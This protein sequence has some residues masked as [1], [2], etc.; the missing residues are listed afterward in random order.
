[1]NNLLNTEARD[2][3]IARLQ[4]FQPDSPRQWGKLSASQ[5]LPHLADPLRVTLGEKKAHS[6]A[7][8][9]TKG[10]I[11]KLLVRWLPWPKSAPTSPD[12]LP[13]TGMTEP[14]SFEEDRQAL[15]LL[16]HRF[17]SLPKNAVLEP[18][19]VFGQL[20]LGDYARLYWRHIDYHLRQFGA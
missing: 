12:F 14:K 16:I 8:A 13:G 6:V 20:S 2:A 3:L 5:I 7:N 10:F 9:V 11:G 19:P 4:N 15:L 18:H 17:V 1:M